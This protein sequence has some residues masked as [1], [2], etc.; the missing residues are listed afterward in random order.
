MDIPA[1]AAPRKSTASKWISNTGDREEQGSVVTSSTSTSSPGPADA[2]SSTLSGT[3]EMDE[4]EN[5]QRSHQEEQRVQVEES[6]NPQNGTMRKSPDS[7]SRQ[8][9]SLQSNEELQSLVVRSDGKKNGKNN[10]SRRSSSKNKS[11]LVPSRLKRRQKG[12]YVR[13]A[14][15]NDSSEVLTGKTFP[16]LPRNQYRTALRRRAIRKMDDEGAQGS[17]VSTKSAE[18]E[19]RDSA[20]G[21][22]NQSNDEEYGDISL[23]MKLIVAGGRVIVQKLIPLSDGRASPAQLVG[24]IQRGDVLLSIDNLSLVS[25]P[26]DQLMEALKPLS[27]PLGPDGAYQR[28]LKLRF[29]T[30]VGMNLLENHE[31]A[32][33]AAIVRKEVMD[34]AN[35]MFSLF[36]M[37]DQLSGTPI[38]EDDG[39]VADQ[40]GDATAMNPNPEVT[41]SQVDEEQESLNI[42]FVQ[43]A[44]TQISSKVAQERI[45]DRERFCSDFFT[46]KDDLSAW[47]RTT[48]GMKYSVDK[49]YGMGMTQSQRLELGTKVMA[50]V[51]SLSYN[52]EELERGAD[53]RSFRKW[54]TTLSLRSRASVRRRHVL[55][56]SSLPTNRLDSQ[57]AIDE[58]DSVTSGDS[59]SL[60]GVD[61]DELLLGLAAHD[62]IWRKQVLDTLKNAI[63]EME[64]DSNDE[65][66]KTKQ[67]TDTAQDI[68]SALTKELGT[69]LFGENMSRIIAQRKKSYALPPEEVTSVL[70]DL[71]TNIASTAPDEISV[72]GPGLNASRSIRSTH[73]KKKHAVNND[74]ILAAL[75]ILDDALPTWLRSFRPLPWDQRRVLWPRLKNSSTGSYGGTNTIF[76]DDSLTVESANSSTRS[77]ASKRNLREIIE[78]QELDIE[79]RAET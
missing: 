48:T 24:V 57:S 62:G 9:T 25:L 28:L 65:N 45:E 19:R 79:A 77:P 58:I 20:E 52:M 46:Y 10:S 67:S 64:N 68:D 50:V 11:N 61:G 71:T 22:E 16:P 17:V 55:D 53:L 41:S 18:E 72:F 13:V 33:K 30:G 49:Q 34:V 31:A 15:V 54:N 70:F 43:P 35:D 14:D 32:Q 42:K 66:P 60:E 4:K 29:E 63:S 1:Y 69:F 74:S 37:V 36:P 47:L 38:F 59:G 76:S 51:K 40:K 7:Y 5:K 44:H 27:S 73:N 2:P 39:R 8:Q 26:I 56:S 75:F 6:Q 12:R 21:E 78:D 3:G 23:G